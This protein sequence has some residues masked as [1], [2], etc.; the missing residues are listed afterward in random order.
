MPTKYLPTT[1]E[2]YKQNSTEELKFDPEFL[3]SM[4][5]GVPLQLRHGLI[6]DTNKKSQHKHQC[7]SGCFSTH[8]QTNC[9]Y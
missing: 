6:K 7:L 3:N 2:T 9:R 1:Q 4:S 8:H 5:I